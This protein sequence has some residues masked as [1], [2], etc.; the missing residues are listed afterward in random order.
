MSLENHI[1]RYKKIKMVSVYRE[2]IRIT[3]T[4]PP[5]VE[6]EKDENGFSSSSVCRSYSLNEE[7]SM[8]KLL[9]ATRNPMFELT[10]TGGG[11]KLTMNAGMFEL[12]KQCTEEYLT[13]EKHEH[14][15]K[16]PVT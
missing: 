10:E 4:S 2:K 3:R 9:D 14:F 6:G 16:I 8:K 11:V 12:L 15:T 1:E 5:E 13:K 7:K